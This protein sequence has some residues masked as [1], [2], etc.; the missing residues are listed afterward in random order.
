MICET[1]RSHKGS[2]EALAPPAILGTVVYLSC[3]SQQ[4]PTMQG[5]VR[6]TPTFPSFLSDASLRGGLIAVED[7]SGK[8]WSS[9]ALELLKE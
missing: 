1:G 8:K 4:L 6:K 9:E 5:R 3:F 2:L 7:R